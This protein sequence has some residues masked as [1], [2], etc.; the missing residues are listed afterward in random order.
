MLSFYLFEGLFEP[1]TFDQLPFSQNLYGRLHAKE[2]EKQ[3]EA[4]EKERNRPPETNL[5]RGVV[6]DFYNGL[7]KKFGYELPKTG[8]PVVDA[9]KKG[10]EQVDGDYNPS[11]TLNGPLVLTP[12]DLNLVKHGWYEKHALQ[13]TNPWG[14]VEPLGKI[15]EEYAEPVDPM[16]DRNGTPKYPG[17]WGSI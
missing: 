8:N 11:I 9:I 13:D 12:E 17:S 6:Q 5:P 7:G 15:P 1:S 4:A 3:I 2:W 16:L 14:E 10:S